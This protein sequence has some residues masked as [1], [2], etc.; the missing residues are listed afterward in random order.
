M[1]KRLKVANKH[2]N[3]LVNAIINTNICMR[4]MNRNHQNLDYPGLALLRMLMNFFSPN[5]KAVSHYGLRARL[6]LDMT[7]R[8]DQSAT[9]LLCSD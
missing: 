3:V 4:H 5:I 6:R 8:I 2:S 1:P 7:F 9:K